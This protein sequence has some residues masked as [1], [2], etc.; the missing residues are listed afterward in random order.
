MVVIA[1]VCKIL[2][3]VFDHKLNLKFKNKSLNFFQHLHSRFIYYF[4]I[5]NYFMQ[6]AVQTRQLSVLTFWHTFEYFGKVLTQQLLV[7][8]R[9]C[10]QTMSKVLIKLRVLVK[11]HTSSDVTLHLQSTYQK[12]GLELFP[13]LT[14][15]MKK[16]QNELFIELAQGA[17]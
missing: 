17:I 1:K 4:M 5:A 6:E 16:Y 10:D 11:A 13:N 9:K 15:L 12:F 8:V 3:P 7:C 14:K 2:G